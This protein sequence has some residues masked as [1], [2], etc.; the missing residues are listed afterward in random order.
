MGLI[1]YIVIY[2]IGF[3]LSLMA[4]HK[5][6]HKW[7]LDVY[8]PPH[9]GWYDDYPSNAHAYVAFSSIWPIFYTFGLIAKSWE[10][11][12]ELSKYIEKRVK[13]DK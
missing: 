6:G 8:D 7:G 4:L 13:N 5:W 2:V 11:L 10:W 12:I 9:E 1:N 3:F